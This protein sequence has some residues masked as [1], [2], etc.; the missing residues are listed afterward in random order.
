M[1]WHS[2]KP[3]ACAQKRKFGPE[4]GKAP[5]SRDLETRLKAPGDIGRI[6]VCD[7]NVFGED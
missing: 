1:S 2:A 5:N 6:D 3:E 4:V 7:L